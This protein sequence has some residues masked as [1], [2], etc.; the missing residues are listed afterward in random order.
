M[1]A[2]ILGGK[3]YI[4]CLLDK[5]YSEEQAIKIFI[6]KTVNDQQSS[7]PSTL[8]N[9]QRSASRQPL[10]KMFFAYQNTPWQYFRTSCNA[11]IRF[12]QN[13]NKETGLDMAKLVGCYLFLFPFVFNMASS[14]SPIMALGGDD[15]AIKEDFWKS[16]IGG[17][18]FIPI[19]GMFINT[20]YSG[21]RGERA[22]TGN[23]FDTA[24]SKLGGFARK[25][26]K[27]NLTFKDL[28]D[29]ICLFTEAGTGVPATSITTELTGAAD[30]VT[31][32]PAKGVLKLL[33]Y[34]DYR[35]KAVTGEE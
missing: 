6:E 17:V 28:F 16:V 29:A 11:I 9:I 18:T 10:A 21:F 35:A 2:I 3:P 7:I 23:W 26:N 25:F 27:G 4:D 20:I 30:V 5:G 13:P 24:A 14:L 34:S 12:K 31:G 8:S 33:G 19:A 1:G 15:D 32:S 22:N